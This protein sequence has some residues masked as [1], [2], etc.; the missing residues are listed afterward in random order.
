[1]SQ[2]VPPYGKPLFSLQ[3][4]NLKPNNSV[5]IWLGNDAWQKGR[6][7]SI[8]MPTRTLII[9]PWECPSFYH[10]P[11]KQCDILIFD[12]GYAELEYVED[13][14][15]CL[16]KAKADIVRFISPSNELTVY[17]KE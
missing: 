10:W 6:N 3:Q 9:P 2:K 12:T 4:K 7:F 5:Y 13:L 1:M 16:Y 17:H 14:V 11:V 15:I 8:S